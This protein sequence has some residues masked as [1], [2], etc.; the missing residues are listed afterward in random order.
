MADIGR[1]LLLPPPGPAPSRSTLTR[2]G[3]GVDLA[4]DRRT[5]PVDEAADQTGA[6][7]GKQFRFRVL[8][9]GHNDFLAG[10]AEVPARI[11]PNAE[12]IRSR[13]AAANAGG[14]N[15]Q[16][17]ASSRVGIP[18]GTPHAGFLAQLIAQEQLPQGLYDPPVKAADRAYRQAG[19][20]PALDARM[21]GTARFR[22]AV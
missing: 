3:G 16:N 18:F 1:L 6:S 15:A 21:G 13:G 20:E 19:A 22:V 4:D 11:D 2:S 14:S 12:D 5:A 10:N 7:R 9:G 8:D 17:A